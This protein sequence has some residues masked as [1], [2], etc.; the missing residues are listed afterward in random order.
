MSIVAKLLQEKRAEFI[1]LHELLETIVQHDGCTLRLAAQFVD[2]KFTDDPKS[3]SFSWL[4]RLGE[5]TIDMGNDD[6]IEFLDL[7]EYVALHGNYH[8]ASSDASI[9]KNYF[10]FVFE[11]AEIFNF[12][13]RHGL[14][15]GYVAVETSEST[16]PTAAT[17][18]PTVP[19]LNDSTEPESYWPWGNHHTEALGHLEAA[20]REF[21]SAYDHTK[22][23]TAP[24]NEVVSNWLQARG[25]SKTNSDVMASILRLD[26]LPTGPR[27]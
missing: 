11:R 18:A 19:A 2:Q 5:N 15:L 9:D 16:T 20:A 14:N 25:V 3:G 4:V 23:R 22:P 7:L 26:G 27:K 17:Q 8:S 6:E 12:L 21:W 24:K 1:S 13:N 10:N